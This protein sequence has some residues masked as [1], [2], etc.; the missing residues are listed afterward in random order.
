MAD[1][2]KTFGITMIVLIA[3]ISMVLILSYISREC[4]SDLDC[5]ENQYCAYNNKCYNYPN[6]Q[7]K[8]FNLL[9]SAFI[10]AIAIVIGALIL[11]KRFIKK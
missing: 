7:Y 11:R 1:A 5:N 3:L 9:P 6:I 2:W 4:N 10:I 8:Y